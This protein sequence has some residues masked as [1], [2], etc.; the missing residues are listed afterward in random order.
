ME[1]YEKIYT[2]IKDEEEKSNQHLTFFSMNNI[3]FED[4]PNKSTKVYD[5]SLFNKMKVF[6]IENN[7]ERELPQELILEEKNKKREKEKLEF[8]S[9]ISL[10]KNLLSDIETDTN[11]IKL[12]MELDQKKKEEIE[13]KEKERLESERKRKEEEERRLK[14][15]NERLEKERQERE[16]LR[17]LREEQ[18]RQNNNI[19]GLDNFNNSGRNIKERLINAGKNYENIKNEAKK[20]AVDTSLRVKT[21]LISKNINDIIINKTTSIGSLDKS[22]NELNNLLKE[23]K[24]I[25][26]RK[27]QELYLYACYTLLIFIFKKLN[28]VDS[29]IVYE[30]I[31][32][33][34][35][36]IFSLN[37]KTLTYMFFQRISNKCP[38]AIPLPYKKQEYD[39]LFPGYDLNKVHKLCRDAEYIYFT[40]LYL[41][42]NKYIT[43]IENYISNIEI[44]SHKDIN[45][46]ISNSFYCFIDIFG[47]FIFTK[48]TNWINRI[49]K[50]KENVMKGLKE[51]ENKVK[52]TESHLVS[53]NK[54]INLNI[55]NCFDKL[56]KQKTTKFCEQMKEIS[57]K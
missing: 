17:K 31:L 2:K 16:R 39:K 6:Y 9:Y 5:S 8:Q 11:K 36:I 38:Y 7:E 27:K 28:E 25:N 35:K 29:E 21:S 47:E 12:E 1:G 15:E 32:I 43:I 54:S 52:G 45:F 40:F 53:I 34:A 20:I 48:K 30:I 14:A 56:R 18:E 23:I 51:E 44:F 4:N 26:D 10:Y 13:K 24:E 50:I 46:L 57:R 19:N 55:E 49:L 3:I 41:D 37:C 22:I 33:N 42:I